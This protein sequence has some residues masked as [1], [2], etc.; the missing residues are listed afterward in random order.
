MAGPACMRMRTL[1]FVHAHPPRHGCHQPHQQEGEAEGEGDG[2]ADGLPSA[3][4]VQAINLHT[5]QGNSTGTGTG[6]GAG[7][8]QYA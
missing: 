7:T 8:V 4:T 6:T 3:C 1:V 2:E 5:T